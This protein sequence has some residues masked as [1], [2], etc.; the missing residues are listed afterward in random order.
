MAKGEQVNLI[1]DNVIGLPATLEDSF[2]RYWV[3]FTRPLHSL[4][5][6]ESDVVVA[7]LKKRYLLSKEITNDQLLDKFLMSEETKREIREECNITLA[8]FQVIM[9]KLKK[10]K[11][12]VDGKLN[13]RFIPNIKENKGNFQLLLYFQFK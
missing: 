2:F 7:F 9:G 4:T 1:P 12:F 3:Q 13:P 11:V 8:H 10:N 5:D 6:R